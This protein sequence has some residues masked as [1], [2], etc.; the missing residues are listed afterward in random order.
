MDF[1]TRLFKLAAK[2]YHKYR[3]KQ[4][5]MR[6][7]FVLGSTIDAYKLEPVLTYDIKKHYCE[8]KAFAQM[9]YFPNLDEPSTYSEKLLWLALNYK[10]PLIARCA[11][12]YEVKK[13]VSEIVG[14]GYCVPSIGVYES[15]ADIPFDSLPD[16]AVFKSTTG[17]SGKQVILYKKDR[18]RDIDLIKSRMAQWL[19]PWNTYYYNNLCITD[20]KVEPRI[21][22]EEMIGDG[23]R[24]DDYKLH[25]FRGKPEVMLI[26]QDRGRNEKRTFVKVSDWEVLPI[27]RKG[28]SYNPKVERPDELDQMIDIAK[29]L[30]EPFP[31]VRID[32]Y[33]DNGHVYVGEMTFSPGLFLKINPVEWDRKLGE[34]L[35]L[36]DLININKE[37]EEDHEKVDQEN[38]R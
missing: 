26:V 8:R 28:K 1:K 13:Y 17:W 3:S 15:I 5:E 12:K 30:S 2:E 25:C 16:R 6:A 24:V 14:E 38:R 19:Y 11:D 37:T 9:G 35:D 4:S 29:K 18:G 36:E 21:I 34:M 31:F 20:E 33:V 27:R 32:F 22:V 7:G 10:N 23:R